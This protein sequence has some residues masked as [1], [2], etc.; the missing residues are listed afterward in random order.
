LPFLIIVTEVD[1]VSTNFA[2]TLALPSQLT[3]IAIIST[4]RLDPEFWGDSSDPAQAV[5]R[6]T[7]LMLHSFG[8]L[9]NLS[10][11]VKSDHN[12]SNVMKRIEKVED[13]DTM[14]SFS[15]AQW[16][17]MKRT[18]PR[19]AHESATVK[20]RVGFTAKILCQQAGAIL[21]GVRRANPFHLLVKLPTM[22]AAGLSV[23]I[24]L[25]FSAETWDIASTVSL[26]QVGLF[27]I[28]S[29]FVALSLLYRSFSIRTRMSRDRLL[30]E[31]AVITTAVTIVS[32]GITLFILFTAFGALMYLGI[33]SIFPEKLMASWP[34][35]GAAVDVLDHIK[36]SLFLA[37]MGVLGGSLGGRS[38]SR[39]MVRGVL[40]INEEN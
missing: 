35:A 15:D 27:A 5:R 23:I 10:H 8:H 1:I 38:D 13:L 19:E 33:V 28:V 39:N 34:T 18:L 24:V 17:L 37:S 40:F 9:L 7:A 11:P 30:T 2:Y 21:R 16:T 14:D 26:G 32:L 31:T 3:N 6:L 4:K 20:N 29:I 12:S 36:L 25:L 22:I